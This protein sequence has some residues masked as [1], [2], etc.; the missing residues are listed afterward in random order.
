MTIII[1]VNGDEH[2]ISSTANDLLMEQS[3]RNF[4]NPNIS[5]IKLPVVAIKNTDFDIADIKAIKFD[6]GLVW[7]K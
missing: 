6:D 7:E 5:T 3:K 4:K 2:V 1:D